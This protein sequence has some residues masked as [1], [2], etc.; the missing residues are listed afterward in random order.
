MNGKRIKIKTSLDKEAYARILGIISR[1]R[2]SYGVYDQLFYVRKGNRLYFGEYE[3]A[4]PAAFIGAIAG[5][6][7]E[8]SWN[9]IIESDDPGV[10]WDE[11]LGP[12]PVDGVAPAEECSVPHPQEPPL[13]PGSFDILRDAMDDA[14]AV[15]C[16]LLKGYVAYTAA[17]R[18]E[19]SFDASAYAVDVIDSRHDDL[20]EFWTKDA[21][22]TSDDI[23][24][25]K[26][27]YVNGR[28][29]TG[30]GRRAK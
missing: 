2:Q 1:T 21:T 27:A 7:G 29:I 19:G 11:I 16:G 25:G 18:V 4:D 3:I 30:T 20:L 5:K 15:P 6:T 28:L 10:N 12:K 13:E 17:G 24:E 26:T 9:D 14:N 22:A 8:L 23:A